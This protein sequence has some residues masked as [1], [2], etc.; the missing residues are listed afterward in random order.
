MTRSA[1]ARRCAWLLL[2]LLAL[3]AV[4]LVARVTLPP[5]EDAGLDRPDLSREE[6]ALAAP[7]SDPMDEAR[8][9]VLIGRAVDAARAEAISRRAEGDYDG[10][11]RAVW[12]A[13]LLSDLS[14]RSRLPVSA[15]GYRERLL[16][17]TP[18]P[19]ATARPA[20]ALTE[21][22]AAGTVRLLR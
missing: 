19:S 8:R 13:S 12:K 7:A 9:Q 5:H 1:P 21:S 20:Q 3:P 22:A 14:L 10:A 2:P 16:P 17:A 18:T 4:A 11:R 15:P 6:R